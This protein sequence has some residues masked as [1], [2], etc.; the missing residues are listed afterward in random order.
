MSARVV[1]RFAPLLALAAVSCLCNS[2]YPKAEREANIVYTTFADEPRHL[3]PAQ[4]Y[5]GVAYGLI[6]N[7]LEPPFQYHLLKRPYTLEPLTAVAIPRPERRVVEW[8][9]KKSEATV[10]TVRIKRGIRYQDHPCFVEA[11][12]HLGP[13]DVRGV[14]TVWDFERKATRE[15]V[16]RDFA[17]AARRLADPRLTCPIIGTLKQNILGLA[18]YGEA[19]E[20]ALEAERRRRREAAGPLYNREEDERLNPIRLDYFAYPLPGFKV[21]D[22]YTFE[23]VLKQPYPQ[24]LYWMAMPFFAP[25]PPEALEFYSQRAVLERGIVFDRNPVGTGPYVLAEFDPTNQLVLERNPNFR[26]ERYPDLPE[27]DPSDK[28]ALAHYGEMKAAGMLEDAGKRMPMVDKVVFRREVEWIPRWTKFLQGYYDTSGISSDVFD[29]TIRLSSTG[30]ALLS[31]EMK[32]RGIRLLSAPAPVVSYFAFNMEDPVVGGYE[33]RK[34]KLRQ[35]IA[36]AFDTEE[37]IAIFLNGQGRVAHSPIPPG[38]H[39][40]IGGKEG[41]NPITHRWDAATERAVRRPLS[42]AKKLLA[43]AGYPGGYGPDGRRLVLYFDNGWKATNLR[44]RLKFVIKQFAKLGIRLV[45]RTTDYNRLGDKVRSG[46]YQILSW[47]WLA[48]YPDPENFLFLLYGPNRAKDKSGENCANYANP[49]FDRLFERM[50]AMPDG[51]Q[52]RAVIEKM[53]ALFHRDAPWFGMVH[54]VFFTLVHEWYKNAWPNPMSRNQMKYHRL[55]ARLRA[56]RRLEW[57]QPRWQPVVVFL[58]VLFALTIPAI[59]VAVRHLR[60]D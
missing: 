24:I 55:D 53:N 29:Q 14:R 42:E 52:R 31:E 57:N 7:I 28:A 22:R 46:N 43:E 58:G 45:S 18:E 47:G 36:T 6:C 33:P 17:L 21:V 35:A 56:K 11:N 9:G 59:R 51:P 2:P 12:R 8:E 4:A 19:L 38:M 39:G 23:V 40:Y 25:V 54:P 49:E 27:P 44:P 32:A 50:R 60:E 15:L 1:W 34:Q 20:A 13:R 10:Y 5:G 48:D 30:D 26:G 3:D 37:L 16:A 41:I